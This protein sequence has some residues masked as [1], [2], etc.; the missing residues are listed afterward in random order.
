MQQQQKSNVR[1]P[2]KF[3]RHVTISEGIWISY[4]SHNCGERASHRLWKINKVLAMIQSLN[5]SRELEQIN[6]AKGCVM[7]QEGTDAKKSTGLLECDIVMA[8]GVTSG[9]IYPG[10]VAMIA[11]RYSFRSIGGTSVGAIAA[12]V[13]AA[14]EYGRRTGGHSTAFDE[15][16]RLSKSLGDVAGDGHSRLFHLFTPEEATKPLLSLVTPI[17]GGGGAL[18]KALTVINVTLAAWQFALPVAI[19]ALAGIYLVSF[20]LSEGHPVIAMIAIAASFA[21]IAVT[22]LVA[23]ILIL[24]NRWLVSWRDNYYGICTGSRSG[25]LEAEAGK[26]RFEGLTPWM[27]RTVQAAA[28]RGLDDSPLTFGDLWSAPLVQGG[29]SRQNPDPS[30]PR[31]IELA[32]IASDISR[33]RTA[34]IPFLETPSPLYVEKAVLH[35]FLPGSV[36]K[37]MVA[38][39]G[40][41]DRRIEQR[42][43]VIRL[44][45]PQDLPIVFGARLSLSFPVLLASMPLMTPDF[46]KAS[47][48]EPVPLRR[49]WFCDGGL[50]SNF[51][52]HFFDSPIPS[53]PTFCL[54]LIDFDAE[55]PNVHTPE[56]DTPETDNEGQDKVADEVS[57]PIAKPRASERTAANRPDAASARD[58]GPG[59]KV[60]GFI[61]MSK[62]NRITPIPFTAFDIAPGSGLMAFLKT[63]LN[64]ARFWSDNQMLIAPG[65]R[66]R[67]VN[68]ALRDDEGGL[69]LDM[70]SEMIAD[71]DLRGRAAG[72]LIATRF[73]SSATTDPETGSHNQPIFANHRWIRFRN[74]MAAFEDLS[75]RFA[76]SRRKSDAA[77]S[78]RKET[79][80]NRM[81][82]GKAKEKIGYPA[83]AAARPFY[84]QTTDDFEQLALQMAK[85]TRENPHATFDAPRPP[86]GAPKTVAGMA[87]RPKMRLRLRP[88]ADNDPRDET[89]EL[90]PGPSA[91]KFG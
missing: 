61:S 86:A 24:R 17:F 64:T 11:R 81:I 9:I 38:H 66:E 76:L 72:L 12:A 69:N 70:T 91:G 75:R 37:W 44:P 23:L 84:R 22:W 52:I 53:R 3:T 45:L 62:G 48:G 39:A 35:D 36:A 42:D 28:G 82:M 26:L 25:T 15:V 34:Q 16:G 89:A 71:L 33:N 79:L 60:W 5:A 4:S 54:N 14:A 31:S 29:A 67:I 21:L 58:P 6:S 10:A 49:V 74:F 51:P 46:A 73:D 83:P 43:D 7:A 77:A 20:L 1:T 30:A 65:V 27:H 13:T 88:L 78:A 59:D 56:T 47:K 55:A 85:A 19:V 63:L 90:P 50:T 32:M 80:L 57:K 87:P 8:G 68:V 2:E 18:K 40:T 41:Y